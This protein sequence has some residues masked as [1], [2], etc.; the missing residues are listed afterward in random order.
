MLMSQS[1]APVLLVDSNRDGLE[2]YSTALAYEG[3]L[4]DTVDSASE[5]LYRV[6]AHPPRV[7]VA[8]LRLRDVR[9]TELI[10]QVRDATARRDLLIV[11][12]TANVQLDSQLAHEAGCDI[13]LP[14]PCLPETL[15]HEV[16][17]VL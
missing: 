2:L 6:A 11:G 13:V 14:V 5:V 4:S 12:L 17:R 9:A 16:R 7:L 1:P 15:V 10:K 3:I 8:G